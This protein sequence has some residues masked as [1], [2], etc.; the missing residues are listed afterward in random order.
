MNSQKK[1]NSFCNIHLFAGGENGT[2]Q[3]FHLYEWLYIGGRGPQVRTEKQRERKE[4]EKGKMCEKEG[5]STSIVTV[6]NN[7]Q[8]DVST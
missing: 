2:K 4:R 3:L 5:V 6:F 8:Y 1:R 7:I